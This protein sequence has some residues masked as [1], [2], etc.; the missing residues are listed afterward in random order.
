MSDL[1]RKTIDELRDAA[2][3][4]RDLDRRSL[5][6]PPNMSL[7]DRIDDLIDEVARLRALGQ[8]VD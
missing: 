4:W 5:W 2:K 6:S 1:A 8:R 3:A 7:H